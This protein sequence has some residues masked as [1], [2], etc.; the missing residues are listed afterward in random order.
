MTL[1]CI[2]VSAVL[3]IA[4]SIHHRI[5]FRQ[6]QKPYILR[7]GN[8][9]MIVSMMFLGVGL[10]GILVLISDLI[11]GGTAAVVAGAAA[12]VTIAGLWFAVPLK[13]RLDESGPQSLQPPRSG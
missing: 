5:L 6:R 13:R 4:P 2:A 7:V 8:Q 3:L 1:V 9:A 12:G 10:T 11:F